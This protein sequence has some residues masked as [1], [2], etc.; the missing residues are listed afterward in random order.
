MVVLPKCGIKWVKKRNHRRKYF[1][2]FSLSS[3]NKPLIG[4]HYVPGSLLCAREQ[5]AGCALKENVQFFTWVGVEVIVGG[6]DSN[7]LFP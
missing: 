4:T 6:D 5:G 1:A 3:F 7:A 2:F